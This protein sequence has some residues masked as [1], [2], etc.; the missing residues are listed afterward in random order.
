MYLHNG[1]RAVK[2]KD[3]DKKLVT[4]IRTNSAMTDAQKFA[5]PSRQALLLT[6]SPHT[7]VVSLSLLQREDPPF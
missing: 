1:K 2:E 7:S 5:F 6:E 4:K 3:T